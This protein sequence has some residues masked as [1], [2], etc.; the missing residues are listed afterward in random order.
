M[1]TPKD[2]DFA[3]TW[4]NGQSNKGASDHL[5]YPFAIVIDQ[6]KRQKM[7][8]PGS[9]SMKKNIPVLPPKGYNSP[10]D[11]LPPSQHN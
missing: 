4:L 2:V 10:G 6:H 8:T 7:N 11:N 1:A 5:S 9:V 3:Y